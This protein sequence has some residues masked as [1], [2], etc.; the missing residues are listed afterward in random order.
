VEPLLFWTI[1][2]LAVLNGIRSAWARPTPVTWAFGLLTFAAGAG[3]AA[4]CLVKASRLPEFARTRYFPI[5]TTAEGRRELRIPPS[6]GVPGLQVRLVAKGT[7]RPVATFEP[8]VLPATPQEIARCRWSA[9]VDGPPSVQMDV[10]PSSYRVV[11]TYWRP[12]APGVVV[13]YDVTP[14]TR[15]VLERLE[16]EA[17]PSEMFHEDYVLYAPLWRL[18]GGIAS[19]AAG[20]GLLGLGVLALKTRKRRQAEA[21]P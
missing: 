18:F 21:R 9:V 2:I 20:V 17:G 1:V 8:E 10:D 4:W 6:E 11:D 5:P 16:L 7:R 12:D 19:V 13:A 15:P 3:I 14:E